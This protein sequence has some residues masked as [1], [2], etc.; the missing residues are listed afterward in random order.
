MSV[1][2]RPL[3]PRVIHDDWPC[4]VT[5]LILMTRPQKHLYIISPPRCSNG[6]DKPH[7]IITGEMKSWLEGLY[8]LCL[9][10]DR[11]EK[12][13]VK[14]GHRILL[15]YCHRCAKEFSVA[16]QQPLNDRT[17][18][19]PLTN[20]QVI[21]FSYWWSDRSLKRPVAFDRN[22]WW[23]VT[24]LRLLQQLNTIVKASPSH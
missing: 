18:H 8:S 23:K 15:V 24:S 6:L 17:K 7:K 16:L 21:P 22:S 19:C 11:I 4:H 1:F 14:K 2:D 12:K 5:T 10:L 20:A 13:L 9:D 3:P